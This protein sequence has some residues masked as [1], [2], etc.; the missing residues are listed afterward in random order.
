MRALDIR[1]LVS[2]A[3][4]GTILLFVLTDI[5]QKAGSYNTSLVPDTAVGGF[6]GFLLLGYGLFVNMKSAKSE[7]KPKE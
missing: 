1:G 7:A 6:I 2:F 4:G 5:L 3:V